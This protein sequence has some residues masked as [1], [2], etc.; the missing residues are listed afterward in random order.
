[1][2]K[3]LIPTFSK[4]KKIAGIELLIKNDQCRAFN[5]IIL[6]KKKNKLEII[7]QFEE[8]TSIEQIKNS[9]NDIA[10][11]PIAL[12]ING[13]PVLHKKLPN[14]RITDTSPI[15]I[16]IPNA[17]SEDFSY[18]IFRGETHSWISIIRKQFLENVIKEFA[19]SGIS[20]VYLSLGVFSIQHI[21]SL[22]NPK[23]TELFTSIY[24][25]N[26]AQDEIATVLSLKEELI[27]SKYQLGED[28]IQHRLL[29]AFSVSFVN[30]LD[31]PTELYN[32]S[33]IKESADEYYYSF[34][35]TKLKWNGLIGLFGV[36][37]INFMLFNYFN[38]KNQASGVQLSM[39]KEQ[40]SQ[41]NLLKQRHQEKQIFFKQTNVL[42]PSKKSWYADQIAQSR[43]LGIELKKLEIAPAIN[44]KKRRI[45]HQYMFDTN[46]LIIRGNS[47]K[48]IYL[49]QWIK[50]LKDLEWIE[51]VSVL[52]YSENKYGSGDFE[53]EL[54][55]K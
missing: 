50:K 32:A 6:N 26:I 46:R 55:I 18:E 15:K 27:N 5:I 38:N 17:N 7:D 10:K 33:F 9:V 41:L 13:K 19:D 49:N 31:I 40:L 44:K 22:L 20:L 3:S 14:N 39:F 54:F 2:L 36:L 11:L 8:L 53:I 48:S 24:Q 23:R 25:L 47:E 34:L 43:E 45:D 29:L 42:K 30:L 37:L 4:Y 1:M 28:E 16:A 35:F 21:L 12:L 51:K 52:P